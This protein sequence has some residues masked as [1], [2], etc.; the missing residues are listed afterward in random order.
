MYKHPTVQY[1]VWKLFTYAEVRLDNLFRMHFHFIFTF[2]YV[3]FTFIL[4][5]TESYCSFCKD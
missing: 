2:G 4:I 1:M 5:L 3:Y